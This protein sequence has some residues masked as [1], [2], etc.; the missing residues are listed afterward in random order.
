[1][2]RG[3]QGRARAPS[4][5]R[6]HSSLCCVALAAS[7]LDLTCRQSSTPPLAP[8]HLALPHPPPTHLQ[9][10]ATT[11]SVATR[12]AY[13][14]TPPPSLH[15]L[16]HMSWRSRP[17]FPH[18]HLL[19]SPAV[20]KAIPLRPS[21]PLPPQSIVIE[22]TRRMHKPSGTPVVGSL[23]RHESPST[24]PGP[25]NISRPFRPSFSPLLARVLCP[26]CVPHLGSAQPV[27][28]RPSS[29]DSCMTMANSSITTT[30]YG[31]MTKYGTA[32]ALPLPRA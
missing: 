4:A 25:P 3:E 22:P 11:S 12:A 21:S 5:L 16:P 29:H 8:S 10:P 6:V 14:P 2:R 17:T 20:P 32:R 7:T 31:H 23:N 24:P 26:V 28:A 13:P 9:L 15:A 1:M 19:T 18:G 27:P 30:K